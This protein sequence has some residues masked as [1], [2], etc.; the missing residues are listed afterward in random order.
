MKIIVKSALAIAL[1]LAGSS[2]AIGQ[3]A[4]MISPEQEPV[5]HKYVTTH[6]VAPVQ[7]PS[8]FKLA[9]GVAIP[10]HVELHVI[11]APDLDAKYEYVGGR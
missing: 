11:D 3:T 1:L 8:D 4:V 7:L 9:V 2:L 6:E 5:I 10:E